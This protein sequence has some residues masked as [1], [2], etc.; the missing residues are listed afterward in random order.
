MLALLAIFAGVLVAPAATAVDVTSGR[1]PVQTADLTRFQPGNIVS[2]EVFFARDT[3]TEA[4][5]QSFLEKRVPNCRSG[6]TCLKD[7]YDT[8]RTTSADAMCS[9]YSGGTRER[10][11]RIIYKVAQA[12]GINPQVILVTLQKEQGLVTHDWPSEW[13]YRI[14][15]GQGCPDTAACD[16]RYHGF[17][18]QVYGAAWQLKR[19]A[20]PAGTSQYFTWYAPGKTWNILWN[21]NHGCGSSPV[22]VQNQA[23]A[24]LYYYTPYQPN[25]AALRAGYGEGDSCSSY[26]NRN[27]YQYFTD[28]FGSTQ[29]LPSPV[30][31]TG[32]PFAD[33]ALSADS[34]LHNVFA[35]EITWL[36]EQNIS[37]GWARADGSRVYRPAEAVL[38][39]AMAA[40]LYRLAGEPDFSAP[41]QSPFVDVQ[42]THVFYKEIAWLASTGVSIGFETSSGWE[43]RPSS[44]VTRDVMA[45]FLYRFAGEPSFD[46]PAESS[47]RDVSANHTFFT[48]I[49]WLASAGISAGWA[50]KDGVE[51]RPGLPVTRDVMAAFLF[52]LSGYLHP[53]VD[54]SA[55]TTSTTY[56]VFAREIAWFAHRGIS[57]GWSQ[58][59]GSRVYRP[60]Q[61]VL[62]DAM[63][64]FLYRL[65]GE[66]EYTAPSESPFADVTTT[67]VFYKEIAWLASTGVS[68]GWART[69]GRWDYRPNQTVT[70]DVMAA[71]LYRFAG[72][73]DIEVPAASPFIDVATSHT[74]YREMSWLAAAGISIGWEVPG[75]AEYRPSAAVT[76]DVMA[77]FLHRLD[78]MSY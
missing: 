15:M 63:A 30:V 77:A 18:N 6:Y 28:W 2:D 17:F 74:F 31:P 60:A 45:A 54:V 19:Y 4:E 14:A 27:F 20:N 35:R 46:A 68:I 62:R 44:S 50:V 1:D 33:V 70:R 57:A 21:P 32:T 22:F 78:R 5:I 9:A 56:N 61:P 73:P 59:D 75:G 41:A 58:A 40:F 37:S 25:A 24:N 10:A 39:D 66:P 38:R 11:A 64:A 12:C 47:F 49:S 29:A 51:F 23:T 7:W 72:K 26:G 69:D 65:A 42:V 67:H 71:F 43:F 52:R 13:R 16:T 3:M 36:A 34:A 8:S 55:V 48:E 53:F 76:R